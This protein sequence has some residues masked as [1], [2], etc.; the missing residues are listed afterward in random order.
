[1][2][3]SRSGPCLVHRLRVCASTAGGAGSVSAR[4]A[5]PP[6]APL[7]PPLLQRRNEL[8]VELSIVGRLSIVW[9][10]YR[11]EG[12]HGEIAPTDGTYV[13]LVKDKKCSQISVCQIVSIS[14]VQSL[15]PVRLFATP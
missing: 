14:S 11:Y 3:M 6:A 5:P 2:R 10:S 4:G 15:S 12:R 1:M 8:W 13:F 9:R 7:P